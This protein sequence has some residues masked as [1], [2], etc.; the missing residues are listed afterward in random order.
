METFSFFDIPGIRVGHEQDAEAGTG[1]T[2]V[3]CEEGAVAGVDVRGGAPGTRETDLLD[4]SNLVGQIHAVVLSGGS[5]FGLDAASGVMELLEERGIGFD[6]GVTRVPI[7]CAAVLFDLACGDW[8]VRPD[9]AMGRRAAES[10][11]D[12]SYTPLRGSVGAGTGATVG[13]FHGMDYAMRG[14][15]GA[16]AFRSGRLA[17]GALIAVNC[18]GDVIDPR[19]GMIVAG[20]RDRAGR[21]FLGTEEAVMAACESRKDVFANNTTIGVIATNALLTKA[22]ARKLAS[23]AHDGLARTMRPAHSMVDGDT[24]FALSTGTVDADMNSL[25]ALAARSVEEA[26]LDAVRSA[27]LGYGFP[28]AGGDGRPR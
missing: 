10:A 16:H 24:I 1:C 11:L 5:A 14:G 4:P 8:R 26:V 21:R 18:L 12:P 7:V 17:V 2:V 28:A 27:S 3:V 13:K 23:M 15:I 6:V 20:A 25:G 9:S 22:Q 19:T